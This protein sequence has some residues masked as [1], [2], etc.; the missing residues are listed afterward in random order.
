MLFR[1]YELCNDEQQKE[2]SRNVSHF[3]NKKTINTIDSVNILKQSCESFNKIKEGLNDKFISILTSKNTIRSK[4]VDFKKQ[5]IS[6]SKDP[7]EYN[8]NLKKLIINSKINK[9]KRYKEFLC[10]YGRAYYLLAEVVLTNDY[11][12][13]SDIIKIMNYFKNVIEYGNEFTEVNLKACRK[14]LTEKE[15]GTTY[16]LMILYIE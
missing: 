15:P 13:Y 5:T 14:F 1:S 6:Y 8:F 7:T 11:D 4:I 16:Y 9:I 12:E 3:I 10:K 2:L